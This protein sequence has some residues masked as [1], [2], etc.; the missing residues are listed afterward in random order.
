MPRPY[1][2]AAVLPHH[3][4]VVGAGGQALLH[5]GQGALHRSDLIAGEGPLRSRSGHIQLG[6]GGKG[7]GGIAGAGVVQEK[8][9]QAR[10]RENDGVHRLSSFGHGFP[11]SCAC[12]QAR[13][14]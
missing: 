12:P 7:I 8:R 10:P 14:L 11:L 3:V 13:P 1:E 4:I 5:G 2:Q 9:R 6:Q